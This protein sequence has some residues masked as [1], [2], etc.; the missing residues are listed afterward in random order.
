MATFIAGI[1]LGVATILALDQRRHA[2]G[3]KKRPPAG[4]MR[5]KHSMM[6]MT[7]ITW[8]H[9][10]F[11]Y[12]N[13]ELIKIGEE[14]QRDFAKGLAS[15]ETGHKAEIPM[16]PSYITRLPT[17]REKGE[18]LALDMGGTNFRLLKISLPGDGTTLIRSTKAKLPDSVLNGDSSDLFGFIA[19]K[20]LS[21]VPESVDGGKQYDLGFTFSFPVVQTAIDQG[22]LL[23]WTKG[24]KTKG[25]VDE[26]VVSLLQKEIDARNMNISIK[27]IINDTV[28]TLMARAL[29]DKNCVVG[30]IIG[31]GCN[32]A[33][34]EEA[35]RVGKFSHMTPEGGFKKSDM[36]IVNTEMG[37]FSG[38][39]LRRTRVDKLLDAQ[40]LNPGMQFWEK[41]VSG[42]YLGELVRLL[43]VVFAEEGKLFLRGDLAE[44]WKEKGSLSTYTMGLLEADEDPELRVVEAILQR[45]M[46]TFGSSLNDRTFLKSICKTISKRAAR[47]AAAGVFATLLQVQRKRV[48]VAVDGSI[49]KLYP[50]FHH[51]MRDA[52]E[53]MIQESGLQTQVEIVDAEDGSG[54]GA[55]AAVAALVGA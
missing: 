7:N 3:K 50:M 55:A 34:V 22:K 53:M 21:F 30:L 39:K 16:I 13:K 20:L 45:D 46:N 51:W 29:T 42:L 33:F 35:S 52:V 15:V 9:K 14:M 5:S 47:V 38:P 36:V 32:T 28:G 43:V 26:E 23:R 17:G 54:V 31:T 19:E 48:T 41:M 24:F 27:A 10:E 4:G 40:S 1:F 11:H 37:N 12:S 6:N 18:Y 2:D 49:F 25:V 8:L 44:I